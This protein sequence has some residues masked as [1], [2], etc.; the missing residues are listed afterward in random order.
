MPVVLAIGPRPDIHWKENL[1]KIL[2]S[3]KVVS[4]GDLWKVIPL[5]PLL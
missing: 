2:G 3:G 1:Y 5:K 4:D